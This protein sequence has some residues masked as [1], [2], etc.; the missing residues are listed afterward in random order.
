MR[1]GILA[2]AAGWLLVG[3]VSGCGGHTDRDSG[4]P[5]SYRGDAA[6]TGGDGIAGATAQTV[7]G[8]G[9]AIAAVGDGSGGRIGSGGSGSGGVP[10]AGGWTAAGGTDNV[11]GAPGG[12][13]ATV[14][15][16]SAGGVA[17][18][19]GAGGAAPGGTSG[20]AGQ[21]G[22]V[23]SGGAAGSA[24]A[25]GE[26]GA[27]GE[28]GAGGGA[29]AP[30]S[31]LCQSVSP[32]PPGCPCTDSSECDG[33]CLV[34][35]DDPCEEGVAG[36][37]ANP[38][39]G[40][41]VCMLE[42]SYTGIVCIEREIC[43]DARPEYPQSCELV[44]QVCAYDTPAHER[45]WCMNR[46]G[47]PV[48]ECAREDVDCPYSQPTRG[49]SCTGTLECFFATASSLAYRCTCTSERWNCEAV[50]G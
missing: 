23:V 32:M 2:T 28:A 40:G 35:A 25:A 48:W 46:F 24:G 3:T 7:A 31:D 29:G 22:A 33:V 13:G 42:E 16:A 9:G 49:S 39:S 11:G 38:P 44:S 14:G 36:I 47:D 8:H 1:A 4:E 19:A 15:G 45:C 20:T 17:G 50:V 18:N 37:C 21:A 6:G 10:G 27:A 34:L 43:P 12:G 26:S 5:S 41:C 30:W